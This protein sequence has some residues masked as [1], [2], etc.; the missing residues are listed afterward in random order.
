M[1][2]RSQPGTLLAHCASAGRY[3]MREHEKSK[4]TFLGDGWV[5]TGDLFSQDENGYFWNLGRADD[6]VKVSGVW[7]SPLETEHVLQKCPALR[8]CAVLGVEDE[9]GLI[10]LRAFVVPAAGAKGS[11]SLEEQLKQFCREKIAPHKIPRSIQFL[12][13]LPKTGS[14]KIDRRRLREHALQQGHA[15]LPAVS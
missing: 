3:Y 2:F 14:G 13:E 11:S 7:V 10:K 9:D 5:N 6:M 8:D 1:L 4:L 12:D 15:P